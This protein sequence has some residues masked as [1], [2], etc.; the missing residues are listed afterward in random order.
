MK[1]KRNPDAHLIKAFAA[2]YWVRIGVPR[3]KLY[4][5]VPVYAHTYT[6]AFANLNTVYSP[7]VDG[8]QDW[9]Y[10]QVN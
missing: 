5:G 9:S 3:S 8:G 2:E 6:L 4:V 7:A 1:T 10:S